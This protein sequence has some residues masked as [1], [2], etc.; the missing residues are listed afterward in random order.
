MDQLPGLLDT[1]DL[2]AI[3]GKAGRVNPLTGLL[4]EVV[5]PPLLGQG[6]EI[7]HTDED[8]NFHVTNPIARQTYFD[9]WFG[10]SKLL[11]K[12]G[13]PKVF[14]HG[15]ANDFSEF[16]KKAGGIYFTDDF[17]SGVSF[18]EDRQG[19]PGEFYLKADRIFNASPKDITDKEISL[20]KEIM[21]VYITKEEQSDA[22][23]IMD[24]PFEDAD[25]YETFTDGEF[26]HFYGRDTQDAIL[27]ILNDNGFDAVVFPDHLVLGEPH[28]STVIFDPKR[29]KSVKNRGT[30]D[31]NNPDY[32]S[33]VTPQTGLIG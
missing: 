17:T 15:S 3:P 23:Q 27:K 30:Y 20:L 14:Y 12:E 9:Q 31:P 29:I 26:W 1:L 13:N 8:G 2:K 24:V 16:K 22:A 6:S 10:G 19:D 33:R 18:T 21:S 5:N 32:L 4:N 7:G 28:T 25:P 11:D